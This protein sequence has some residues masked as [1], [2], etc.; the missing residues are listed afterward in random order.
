MIDL[1]QLLHQASRSSAERVTLTPGYPATFGDARG[2]VA[3][4]PSLDVGSI[5]QLLRSALPA[6]TL[7]EMRWGSESRYEL[8]VDGSPWELR[9]ALSEDKDLRVELSRA[10]VARP[11]AGPG[12]GPGPGP[13]PSPTPTTP[14]RAPGPRAARHGG[15]AS[16]LPVEDLD[17]HE[18][19]STGTHL[20]L[21]EVPLAAANDP[22]YEPTY[23]PTSEPAYE[24]R[25][26]VEEPEALR[27]LAAAGPEGTA[28]IYA[29]AAR[30]PA[31]AG[32]LEACG[33]GAEG[34][35]RAVDV[36]SALRYGSWPVL[37]LAP[38][39]PL[40][41]DPAYA[42]LRE[43]P[44]ARRRAIFVA[45]LGQGASGA[46]RM[47]AFAQSVDLCLSEDA[48]AEVAARRLRDGRALWEQELEP[49]RQ[50]LV[51]CGKA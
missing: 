28:L 16:A 1:A 37:V 31:V 50:A 20:C 14:T 3:R 10:A 47:E 23:E 18:A 29:P 42:W 2:A 40:R 30:Q 43:L 27:R 41:A 46:G 13:S 12:P 34:S 6:E 24:T 44:M 8:A 11:A 32:L 49:L 36:F 7:R 33:L 4:G 48:P 15:A 17:W 19:P 22:S 21:A 45:L 9:V 5:K 39:G 35:E 26:P 38:A 51:A 25:P